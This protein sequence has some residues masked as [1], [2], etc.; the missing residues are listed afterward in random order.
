[1]RIR[2]RLAYSDKDGPGQSGGASD[3]QRRQVRQAFGH[4]GRPR[5]VRIDNEETHTEDI[6]RPGVRP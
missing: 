3:V 1:V 5:R 2:D 4:E 6:S